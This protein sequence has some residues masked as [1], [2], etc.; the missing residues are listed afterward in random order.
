MFDYGGGGMDILKEV[1]KS[2]NASGVL[3]SVLEFLPAKLT[4]SA[5]AMS[6]M[7]V[8]VVFVCFIALAV[9]DIITRC[10]AQS[11]MLYEK[12]YGTAFTEKRGNIVTFIRYIPSAHRWRYIDSGSLRDG[13]FSK[14]L[15]YMLMIIVAYIGDFI[16]GHHGMPQLFGSLIIAVLTFTEA[17]SV[18][19]NLGQA[20]VAVA[21]EIWALINKRK[22]A[23]K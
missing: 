7:D 4:A 17:L 6:M 12:T 1:W 15:S 19:E 10:I 13:F 21:K 20:H 23:I 16:V 3:K 2:L 18:L 9:I 11:A 5:V 8:G 22:E 14:I